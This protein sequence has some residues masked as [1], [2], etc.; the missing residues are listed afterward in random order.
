MAGR[1]TRFLRLERPHQPGEQHTPVA[2]PARFAPAVL[3]GDLDIL[4]SERSI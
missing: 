2:N 4:S 1:F 3:P